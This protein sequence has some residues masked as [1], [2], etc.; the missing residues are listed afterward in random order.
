[1]KNKKMPL[2]ALA[3]IAIVG[4]VGVTLA[5]F[6]S[7][8]EFLN[9]FKT[10]A[11]KTELTENFVSPKDWTPGATTNKLVQVKNTG[12]IPIAARVTLTEEWKTEGGDTLPNTLEDGTT[13]VVT[14]N[15]LDTDKWKKLDENS[16]VYYYN[17]PI[18]PS[19]P[20]VPVT[21]MESVTFNKD[22]KIGYAEK[23]FESYK[24]DPE[25]DQEEAVE[26]EL[27][28]N[29]TTKKYEVKAADQDTINGKTKVSSRKTYET[30]N[31]SYAG[32]TYTLNIFIETVQ[33]DEEAIK[34]TWSQEAADLILK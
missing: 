20:V 12:D 4:V 28:Y 24:A 1:M 29:D 22:V 16:M 8:A 18:N 17:E 19:D 21:F 6:T 25:D 15:G 30:T 31:D 7:S 27:V 9:T 2:I 33:A 32:A 34:N 3:I 26:I 10:K 23:V 13:R 5:Y 14:L 11:Y